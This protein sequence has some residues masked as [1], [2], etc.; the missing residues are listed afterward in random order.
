MIDDASV[1]A[2]LNETSL[3][4]LDEVAAAAVKTNGWDRLE[5]SNRLTGL[6]MGNTL[7]ST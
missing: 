7:E 2:A 1:P 6:D 5:L 3:E 4:A